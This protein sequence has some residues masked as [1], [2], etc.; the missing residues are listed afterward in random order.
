MNWGC[1]IKRNQLEVN[2]MKWVKKEGRR[3]TWQH[4]GRNP[5]FKMTVEETTNGWHFYGGGF[6]SLAYGMTYRTVEEAKKKAE[7]WIDAQTNQRRSNKGGVP[8]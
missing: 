7:E 5:I 8:R 2:G 1:Q 4:I 6:N 3:G